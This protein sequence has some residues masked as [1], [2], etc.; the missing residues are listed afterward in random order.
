MTALSSLPGIEVGGNSSSMTGMTTKVTAKGCSYKEFAA[1]KPPTYNGECDPILVMKWI[2]EMELVFA[3]SKCAEEDKVTYALS[4]L[5]SEAT[6]WW[7]AETGGLGV[8]AAEVKKLQE[9]FLG[10]EQKDMSTKESRV[11]RFISGM[12]SSLREWVSTR[13]PTTFQVA[14]HAAEMTEKEKNR[15]M[16]DRVG[17]KRKWDGPA[18]YLRK[19]KN[20]RTE[21]RG[22]RGVECQ[23]TC[24]GIARTRKAVIS[25]DRQTIF[26]QIARRSSGA[27]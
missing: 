20:S 15:H 11:E 12:R 1:C 25:A 8:A 23:G 22:G 16:I 5:R 13:D 17:D 14:V 18:T 9:E 7:D 2:K 6:L 27:D 21:P 19:E 24:L 4:M 10:L 26:G 3:T